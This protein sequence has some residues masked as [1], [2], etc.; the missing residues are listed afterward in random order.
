[1]SS[2]FTRASRTRLNVFPR[3]DIYRFRTY[4]DEPGLFASLKP[5]YEEDEYRFEVP[6]DRFDTVA[7]LL[8]SYEY[9]PVIIDDPT[10]F[11][12]AFKRFSDHPRVLFKHAIERRRTDRYTLFLLDSRQA[13]RDAVE[14]GAIE[15]TDLDDGDWQPR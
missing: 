1:M 15:I 9:E 3:D 10:P 2:E 4:F 6:S 5:F 12:V 13:V 7:D 8:R 14:K 11:V